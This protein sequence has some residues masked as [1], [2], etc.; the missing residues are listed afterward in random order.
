MPSAPSVQFGAELAALTAEVRD[1]HIA[2]IDLSETHW[3]ALSAGSVMRSFHTQMRTSIDRAPR[4]CPR[5]A[6]FRVV[7]IL[8][9]STPALILLLD[10]CPSRSDRDDR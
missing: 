8:T 5:T 7:L 10:T 6:F 3:L 2:K 9:P 1:S 4:V